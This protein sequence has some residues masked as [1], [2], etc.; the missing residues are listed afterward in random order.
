M[1][2]TIGS[3]RV[4]D[5]GLSTETVECST[6]DS[7]KI[8]PCPQPRVLHNFIGLR[9]VYNALHNVSTLE[10]PYFAGKHYVERVMHL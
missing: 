2:L 8:K 6:E 10:T 9:A 1:A 4:A 3:N 7:I 5:N